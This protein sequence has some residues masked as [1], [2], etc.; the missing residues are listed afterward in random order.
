MQPNSMPVSSPNRTMSTKLAHRLRY[1]CSDSFQY[2]LYSQSAARSIMMKMRMAPKKAFGTYGSGDRG[3]ATTI[4]WMTKMTR[5]AS[6]RR[7]RARMRKMVC[8]KMYDPLY[9]PRQPLMTLLNPTTCA[10][11]PTHIS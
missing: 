1:S 2:A 6:R 3:M 11:Q 10:T 5:V 7:T 4:S 9:P 8:E